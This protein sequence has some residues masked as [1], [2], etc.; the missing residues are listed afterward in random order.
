MCGEKKLLTM[1]ELKPIAVPPHPELAVCTLYEEYANRAALAA[2]MPPKI[3]K[4]R[5]LDKQYFWNCVN[6]MYPGEVQAM[7]EHANS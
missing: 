7:V 1:A 6:T 2:L 4:G 3:A 5:Q